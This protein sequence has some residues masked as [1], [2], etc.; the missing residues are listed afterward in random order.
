MKVAPVGDADRRGVS[1]RGLFGLGLS[2][3]LDELPAVPPSVKKRAKRSAAATGP[4]TWGDLRDA[5]H[6]DAVDPLEGQLAHI[7]R[8]V[9]DAAA[10]GPGAE[11]LVVGPPHGTVA[12]LVR[13]R[14]ASLTCSMDPEAL[15]H[16]DD[17]FDAVLSAFGVVYAERREQ[18]IAELFR[19]ARADGLVSLATWTRAGFMGT[20][21]DLAARHALPDNA[22][23]PT[24]WGRAQVM[25]DELRPHAGDDTAFDA[26]VV[27]LRF[28][29]P[30][31]AWLA[32]SHLPGPVAAA[33]ERLD[34]DDREAMRA[35]FTELLP[36]P[37]EPGDA[38]VDV[39]VRAQLIAARVL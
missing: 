2:R 23:D 28:A 17:S 32:F 9:V 14:G 26:E 15:P 7:A 36:A 16:H 29:S 10:V 22:P 24:E 38:G 11:I 18:A 35:E 37:S 12:R 1:R 27:T 31:A 19:V 39:D 20:W 8:T 30:G 5:A 34:D 13:E 33:I 6:P 21:L 3:A 4:T 25:R